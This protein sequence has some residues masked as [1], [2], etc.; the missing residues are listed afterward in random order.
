[1]M[2][3]KDGQLDALLRAYRHA[4]E[5]PEPGVDFMPRLWGKIESRKRSASRLAR[6]FVT[7]A[8]AA[9]ALLGLFLILPAAQNSPVYTATYLEILDADRSPDTLAY[10]DIQTDHLADMS[11]R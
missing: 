4:V 11:A 6:F 10:A 7:A 9:S 1:M 8:A 3:D 2:G 5:D